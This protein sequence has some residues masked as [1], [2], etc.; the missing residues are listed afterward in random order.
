MDKSALN[1]FFFNHTPREENNCVDWFVKNVRETK[2]RE[3]R[4]KDGMLAQMMKE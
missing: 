1:I 2:E 4:E 3:L